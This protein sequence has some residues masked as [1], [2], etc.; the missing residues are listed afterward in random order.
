MNAEDKIT[1]AFA[2]KNW[3]VEEYDYDRTDGYAV[4]INTEEYPE[5]D[6]LGEPAPAMLSDAQ[7]DLIAAY[8]KAFDDLEGE[9]LKT[10]NDVTCDGGMVLAY[11]SERVLLVASLIPDRLSISV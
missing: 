11:H 6:A 3:Q 4:S 9:I 8:A 10:H 2:A 1:A 5:V 7:E